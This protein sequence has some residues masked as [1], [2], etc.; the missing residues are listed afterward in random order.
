MI[1]DRFRILR[2]RIHRFHRR[3]DDFIRMQ[4]VIRIQDEIILIEFL[5]QGII[6]SRRNGMLQDKILRK[7]N[8]FVHDRIPGGCN[9]LTF[10]GRFGRKG[11]KA[12][13]Q[14]I[15]HDMSIVQLKI[16]QLYPKGIFRS[17]YPVILGK[18]V[19]RSAQFDMIFRFS[20]ES[21]K[22]LRTDFY[23]IESGEGGCC[24]KGEMS[25][26]VG[27]CRVDDDSLIDI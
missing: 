4:I 7:V 25:V 27:F 9:F 19:Q 8:L 1:Q 18:S 20:N 15:H 5:I 11:G 16:Q 3:G 2:F 14:R 13:L 26:P 17:V 6:G 23:I 10:A 24:F 21:N 22:F 12:F